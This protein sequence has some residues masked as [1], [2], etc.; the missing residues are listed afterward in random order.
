MSIQS[1]PAYDLPFLYKFG[2]VASNDA[3]T[4]NTKLDISLG[5]VRDSTNSIDIVFAATLAPFILNGAL[6]G[7]N[8]LDTGTLGANKVYGI[9]AIGDST[10]NNQPA[11]IL[12]LATNAVPTMPFGYDS[13]RLVGYSVTDSMSHFLP[14]YASGLGQGGSR[15]FTYDAPQATA[16]TSGNATSYT[17][18]D[19][20]T[21][22]PV[23]YNNVL[24][25]PVIIKSVFTPN[26]ANDTLSMQ[27]SIGTGDAIVVN[28]QV[29]SVPII[30]YS[31][32][33]AS[34]SSSVMS[35]KYKL[36]TSSAHVAL[37]VAGFIF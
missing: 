36:S 18:V 11:F 5:Q 22:V 26:A 8:G 19:L 15:I 13:Y 1:L 3:T 28:G 12:S 27:P 30:T 9:G 16:V 10:N 21:L 32:V 29:A 23:P 37:S 14:F 34:I 33:M 7:V 20:S 24:V 31:T 6:N 25:V 17:A 2:M 4:P 35:I